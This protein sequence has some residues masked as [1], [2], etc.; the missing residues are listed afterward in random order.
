MEN[1]KTQSSTVV[2]NSFEVLTGLNQNVRSAGVGSLPVV[3]GITGQHEQ[4]GNVEEVCKRNPEQT[5]QTGT[6]E[7]C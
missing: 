5:P 7:S 6:L 3:P 4:S 1:L 2:K